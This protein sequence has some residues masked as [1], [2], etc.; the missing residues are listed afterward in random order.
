MIVVSVLAGTVN[1]VL[2]TLAPQYV[3]EVLDTDPAD[4]AYVFAPTALGTVTALVVAPFMIRRWS[5]RVAAVVGLAFSAVTLFLLG[6]I[7]AVANVIDTVN[8]FGVPNRLGL[9]LSPELRATALLAIPVAFG[10][11]LTATSVQTYIN[12]RVPLTLQG[13]TFAMQSSLRNGAAII[14]LVVLGAAAS[15]FGVE[16]VLLVSPLLLLAMG[17]L[18]IAVSFRFSGVAQHSTLRVME[19]FWEEPASAPIER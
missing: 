18:L 8:P 16:A 13:R 7:D 9:D 6:D 1:I 5:E 19:T 4:T 10:V 17:Y 15:S 2:V 12:R 14:P 11:A 3:S